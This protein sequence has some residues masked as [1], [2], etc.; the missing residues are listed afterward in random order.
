[1][2]ARRRWTPIVGTGNRI[3]DAKERLL[4]GLL[5]LPGRLLLGWRGHRTAPLERASVREVLV[6]RLDR[7]GDVIM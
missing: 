4:V 1:M 7:I 2:P 6:L 3:Y 5:D